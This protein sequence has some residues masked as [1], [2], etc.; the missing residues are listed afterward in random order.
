MAERILRAIWAVRIWRDNSGQDMLEY[1][2]YVAVIGT[3]Y[4]AVSPSVAASVS[5]IFSKINSSMSSASSTS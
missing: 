1:A 3:L 4:A 2:L 5:T